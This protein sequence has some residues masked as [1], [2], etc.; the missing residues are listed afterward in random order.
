VVESLDGF[1]WSGIGEAS[2][3]NELHERVSTFAE[4]ARSLG[5]PEPTWISA[6]A[7]LGEVASEVEARLSHL[8]D[9]A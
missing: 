3:P 2:S 4:A 7:L 5:L 9:A 1:C 6:D 8:D